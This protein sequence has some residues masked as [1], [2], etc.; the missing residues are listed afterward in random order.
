MGY[1]TSSNNVNRI[2]VEET[3]F[4]LLLIRWL[5]N[6]MKSKKYAALLMIL[7]VIHALDRANGTLV[8]M[9]AVLHLTMAAINA[10]HQRNGMKSN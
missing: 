1:F 9:P 8:K 10:R 6:G 5:K 4:L 3:I 2:G 7:V